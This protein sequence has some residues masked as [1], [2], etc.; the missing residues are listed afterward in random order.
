MIQAL[1]LLIERRAEVVNFREEILV[2]K[3]DFV[4]QQALKYTATNTKAVV[5]ILAANRFYKEGFNLF[6]EAK[7]LICSNKEQFDEKAELLDRSQL[8][9]GIGNEFISTYTKAKLPYYFKARNSK[10]PL[11]V[12]GLIQLMND[13]KFSR[14]N[15]LIKEFTK[16]INVDKDFIRRSYTDLK[17]LD[18]SN[19][20]ELEFLL[21][22]LEKD[23]FEE[24]IGEL[25]STAKEDKEGYLF[26]N[27]NIKIQNHDFEQSKSSLESILDTIEIETIPKDFTCNEVEEIEF[28]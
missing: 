4:K 20:E 10:N 6:N 2:Q 13:G 15:S 28:L 24:V 14:V 21:E 9:I 22:C 25:I 23:S 11:Y 5:M 1:S 19:K 7:N 16:Y 17:D 12:R 27:H 8:L 3:S 26:K 18:L